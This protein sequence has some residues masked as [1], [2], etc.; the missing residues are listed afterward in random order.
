MDKHSAGLTPMPMVMTTHNALILKTARVLEF[1]AL[2]TRNPAFLFLKK[3][4]EK[5]GNSGLSS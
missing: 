4:E 5:P 2:W 1:C 3:G